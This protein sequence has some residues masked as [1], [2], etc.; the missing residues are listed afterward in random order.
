MV[1][2]M[3]GNSV[4]TVVDKDK[5]RLFV[6]GAEPFL[7]PVLVR[8]ARKPAQLGDAR[9]YLHRSPKSFTSCAPLTSALPSVPGLW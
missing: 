1:R 4:L 2:P 8:M 3:L 5:A 9:P 6:K 7:Q